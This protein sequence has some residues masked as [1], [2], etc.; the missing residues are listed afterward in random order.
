M[1]EIFPTELHTVRLVHVAPQHR[2]RIVT[3]DYCNVPRPFTLCI[4]WQKKKSVFKM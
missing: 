1:R 3:T 2:D 4:S